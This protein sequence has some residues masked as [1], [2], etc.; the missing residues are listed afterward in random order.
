VDFDR[1]EM[2]LVIS[3][4]KPVDLAEESEKADQETQGP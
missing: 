3:A 2:V 4:F 1:L